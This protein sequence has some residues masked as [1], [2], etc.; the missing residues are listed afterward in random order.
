MSYLG[1]CKTYLMFMF[2]LYI[3]LFIKLIYYSVEVAYIMKGSD[4]G[5]AS[6][7]VYAE[8]SVKHMLSGLDYARAIIGHYLVY[9]AIAKLILKD[10]EVSE[11]EKNLLFET[12][13]LVG[14]E[15]FLEKLKEQNF[16]AVKNVYL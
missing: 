8:N 9:T 5:E 1:K 4:I 7:L 13:E 6:T 14:N 10:I 15:S 2:L 12:S 11:N 16:E 3:I